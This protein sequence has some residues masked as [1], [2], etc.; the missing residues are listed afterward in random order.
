MLFRSEQFNGKGAFNLPLKK[1]KDDVYLLFEPALDFLDTHLG[2]VFSLWRTEQH[3]HEQHMML[4]VIVQYY[5]AEVTFQ[6][7]YVL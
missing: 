5:Q 6:G 1:T 4:Q 2:M 3:N 7:I